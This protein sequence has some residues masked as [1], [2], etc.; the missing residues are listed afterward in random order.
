MTEY[1]ISADQGVRLT[2]DQELKALFQ[3]MCQAW[4]EGDAAAYGACFT[5]DCDYVSY[6]GTRARGREQVVE[7]HDKLFRGVLVGSAL[8]GELVALATRAGVGWAATRR[9]TGTA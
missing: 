2:D 3:R 1:T 6:D 7:S 9:G 4:T 5:A 8:R